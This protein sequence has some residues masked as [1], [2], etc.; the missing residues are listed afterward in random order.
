MSPNPILRR[1]AVLLITA[2]LTFGLFLAAPRVQGEDDV[3]AQ[4]PYVQAVGLLEKWL[5]QEVEA[6]RLPSLSIALVD[7]QRVVWSRGF[8]FQDAERKKRATGD[9]IYRAGSVSK[10]VTAIALMLLVQMGL[11]DLDAPVTDYLPDFKPRNPFNKKITLRQ[12]LSHHSGLV[13]ETPV[14]NYF[15]T[16]N[17]PLA[18]MVES[19]N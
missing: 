2:G 9:T 8:G 10:P 15:D 14:G 12:M 3:T 5:Q 17:P 1:A 19:L 13:R 6:K 7:G 11:I 18:K 4:E 16:T